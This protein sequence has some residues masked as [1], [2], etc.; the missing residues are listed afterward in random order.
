[1]GWK[2][3]LALT[4]FLGVVLFWAAWDVGA[5]AATRFAET[6]TGALK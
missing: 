1:M 2:A 5:E 3:V 4:A 6:V